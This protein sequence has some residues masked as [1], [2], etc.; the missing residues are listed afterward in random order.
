MT[1]L[2]NPLT[3]L[4]LGKNARGQWVVRDTNTGHMALA[5]MNEGMVVKPGTQPERPL[6]DCF[7][8]TLAQT[9]MAD[10]CTEHEGCA[11]F[12]A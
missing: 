3:L 9:M 8:W 12:K 11:P 4:Q 7:A 10:A 6:L 5:D 1:T 2:R